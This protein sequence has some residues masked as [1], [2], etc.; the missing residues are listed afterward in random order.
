MNI[1]FK[2]VIQI[3]HDFFSSCT[4]ENILNIDWWKNTNA[5]IRETL[6]PTSPFGSA[7]KNWPIKFMTFYSLFLS[8]KKK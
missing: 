3:E 8:G 6:L 7:P 4:F 5:K 1:K 2:S